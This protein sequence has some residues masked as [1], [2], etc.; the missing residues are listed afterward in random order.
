[1]G[2]PAEEEE[3]EKMGKLGRRSGLRSFP[4]AIYFLLPFLRFFGPLVKLFIALST[5]F[6]PPFISCGNERKDQRT[7]K[8]PEAVVGKRSASSEPSQRAVLDLFCVSSI[9]PLGHL[10]RRALM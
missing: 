2:S 10:L 3:A 8:A 5:R 9:C 7:P 6:L 4:H 1:M